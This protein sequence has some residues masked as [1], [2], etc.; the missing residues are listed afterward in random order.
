MAKKAVII[1][2]YCALFQFAFGSIGPVFEMVHHLR[3]AERMVAGEGMTASNGWIWAPGYPVLVA[4]HGALFTNG[5]IIKGTQVIASMYIIVL[6]F[7][8]G[9][10][11]FSPRAGYV[12]AWLYALSPTQIFF[13][14]SLWRSAFMAACCCLRC[15]P[16]STAP[17]HRATNRLVSA[18]SRWLGPILLGGCVLFGE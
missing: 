11:L 16:L 8:L 1:G 15:G 5:M 14:Q 10:R 3:L 13:A 18:A 9:A 7:R 17:N 6:M 2:H 12:A 4:L